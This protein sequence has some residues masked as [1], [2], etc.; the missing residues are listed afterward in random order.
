[1]ALTTLSLRIFIG[2]FVAT[3]LP[4][5][6]II[7]AKRFEIGTYTTRPEDGWTGIG[8][9]TVGQLRVKLPPECLGFSMG[10][11]VEV[12]ALQNAKAYQMCTTWKRP[13]KESSCDDIIFKG[14]VAQLR[15][16]HGYCRWQWDSVHW[17]SCIWLAA[18]PY[19]FTNPKRLV[20]Y[21]TYLL[22]YL[23]LCS[24]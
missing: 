15:V 13:V 1:M 17:Y 3:R 10:L 6:L 21:C 12:A 19:F 5:K 2:S 14:Q 18:R 24:K 20:K 16:I 11:V 4:S 23:Y 7:P 8:Y 22:I 9:R